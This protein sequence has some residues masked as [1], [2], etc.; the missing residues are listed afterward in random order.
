MNFDPRDLIDANFALL[1][2]AARL[3]E[4]DPAV[5]MT[6]ATWGRGAD[7][8]FLLALQPFRH[9]IGF[10]GSIVARVPC[11]LAAEWL[12]KQAKSELEHTD[13]DTGYLVYGAVFN[14]WAV[15]RL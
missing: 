13:R 3:S 5:L 15:D 12:P 7:P 1:Q 10:N 2:E 8:E 4:P 6:V 9:G 14:D 11:E